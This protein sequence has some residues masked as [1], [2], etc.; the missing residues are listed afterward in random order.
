MPLR[1]PEGHGGRALQWSV[2]G[3]PL[4]PAILP[5]S[6]LQ[7]P[8]DRGLLTLSVFEEDGLAFSIATDQQPCIKLFFIPKLLFFLHEHLNSS[9][10]SCC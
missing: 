10:L 3:Y 2:G 4:L 1:E 6:P 9:S 7:L 5:A 8:Q